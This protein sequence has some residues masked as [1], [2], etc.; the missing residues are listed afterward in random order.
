M[1]KMGYSHI[2]RLFCNLGQKIVKLWERANRV[3]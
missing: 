3:H 2:C 1:G